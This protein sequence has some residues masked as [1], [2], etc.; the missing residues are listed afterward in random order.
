MA[1]THNNPV[2]WLLTDN[3]PGHQNQ[4]RGLGA[5]LQA[6]VGAQVH[7]L[8]ASRHPLSL[9]QVWRGNFP[10]PEAPLP[11]LLLAAG[12]GTHRL[13][14]ALRR[15]LGV[16]AVVLMKPSFP[17]SWVEGAIISAHDSPPERPQVLRIQGTLNA[18]SPSPP[19][20]EGKQ[21]LMLMGGP[22]RHY[23]WDNA[24][25]AHQIQGLC[26]NYPDWQWTLA[27]SRRTP[28][29]L[30]AKLPTISN[31]AQVP[32]DAHGPQWLPAQLRSSRVA[33]VTPD[34]ASM[35]SEALT[36]GLATGLFALSPRPHSRVARG[37]QALV[38]AEQVHQWPDHGKVMAPG[39][40]RPGLWETDRAARWL[41]T[42]FYPDVPL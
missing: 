14:L 23:R 37:I 21:A 31:L 24:A 38:R 8:P 15:R 26:Q 6:L 9:R 28:P 13:L 29:E 4:L 34:S 36:S 12:H 42:R 5:R 17:L 3:R 35:V 19:Q 33:W 16:P 1:L 39:A 20:T 22:S 7:E 40:A 27:C 11:S 18:A 2:V 41:I 10:L 25:L 32:A 30:N